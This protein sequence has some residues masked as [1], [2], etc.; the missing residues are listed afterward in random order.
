[1]SPEMLAQV[2]ALVVLEREKEKEKQ[3]E[4]LKD[5][6]AMSRKASIELRK[7]KFKEP[8]DKRAV[9]FISELRYDVEDFENLFKDLLD[10][11]KEFVDF[12]ENKEKVTQFLKSCATFGHKLNKKLEREYEAY[13]VANNS[14]LGWSTE[15][16][17]RQG[18]F[19]EDSLKDNNSSWLE[20]DE[21]E[22]AEDKL[23]RFRNAERQAK[24]AAKDKTKSTKNFYQRGG[25]RRNR[26]DEA[27]A[28]DSSTPS[29]PA[30]GSSSFAYK[31]GS[32]QMYQPPH[33]NPVQCHLCDGFGH[34]KKN[35]PK[36]KRN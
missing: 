10:D 13:K 18:A 17:Y 6:V 4:E 28:S 32:Q 9:G 23:K 25:R 8:Q 30:G 33:S 24:M 19:F 7:S 20:K 12:N 11:N 5:Y 31:F 35:C 14:D 26:W 29:S 21:V 27:A 22:S 1:M 2:K 3:K 15:K 16:F 36:L 34:Y